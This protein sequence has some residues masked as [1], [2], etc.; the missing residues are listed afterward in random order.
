MPLSFALDDQRVHRGA[1]FAAAVGAEEQEVLAAKAARPQRV[2]GDVVVDLAVDD[3]ACAVAAAG[4]TTT[5]GSASTTGSSVD[6]AWGASPNRPTR[7]S[8]R[9]LNTMLVLPPVC[10]RQLGNRHAGLTCCGGES[11]HKSSGSYCGV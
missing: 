4:D 1:A 3:A 8:R 5:Y 11:H 6:I 7:N 9:H 2:L 10:H